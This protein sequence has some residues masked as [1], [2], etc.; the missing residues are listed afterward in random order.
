MTTP[1]GSFSLYMSS[2]SSF[3]VDFGPAGNPVLPGRADDPGL[4]APF[5]VGPFNLFYDPVAFSCLVGAASFDGPFNLLFVTFPCRGDTSLEVVL[6]PLILLFAPNLFP[7]LP[8]FELE[9]GL[10]GAAAFC[11]SSSTT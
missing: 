8:I 6:P 1:M 3:S 7:N 10:F 2:T 11:F 5:E 9:A 4:G